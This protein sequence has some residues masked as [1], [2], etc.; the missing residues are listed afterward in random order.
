MPNDQT[1]NQKFFDSLQ[2]NES[3]TH[4]KGGTGA[5]TSQ[6]AP[7]NQ[8]KKHKQDTHT[9]RKHE[10]VCQAVVVTKVSL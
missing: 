4:K 5:I 8:T 9:H 2:Q 1:H 3:Y 10:T 7:R 6:G